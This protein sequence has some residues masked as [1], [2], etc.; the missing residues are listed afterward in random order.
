[1]H[2]QK[3]A[4]QDFA[5]TETHVH[6]VMYDYNLIQQHPFN[7]PLSG[8]TRVNLIISTKILL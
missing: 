2:V 4:L 3:E 5:L 7:G 8:T 6:A 1:M